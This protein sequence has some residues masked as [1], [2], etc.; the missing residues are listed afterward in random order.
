MG[1]RWRKWS[2][3]ATTLK[4]EVITPSSPYILFIR[5]RKL[6]PPSKDETRRKLSERPEITQRGSRCVGQKK[7]LSKK[8][9]IEVGA[10]HRSNPL[11][12]NIHT[13]RILT[14]ERTDTPS[15]ANTQSANA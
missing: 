10:T 11:A 13:I 9:V 14:F 7:S 3:L 2:F 1:R 6:I 8:D 5:S 4:T 12:L 15:I